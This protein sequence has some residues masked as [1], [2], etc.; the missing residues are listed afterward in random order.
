[1]AESKDPVLGRTIAGKFLVEAYLG[2]GAM[3]AVYRAKQL[4]LEKDVAIKIM[5]GDH[6]GDATYVARFQREA[7]AASRLD[8]PNSMRVIDFGQED[9]GLLYIAMEFLD[10]RDLFRVLQQEWPLPPARIADILSQALAALAVAHEMGIV[11]RDL[12]P[13]NIMLLR[14]T[15]DEGRARD[16]VKVCDFGIAKFTDR[17]D[18]TPQTGGQKLTT[19]GIVVGTPEYMSPEQGKGEALDARSDLYAMGVILY[20]LLTGR[21]PFDAETALG[22]VLKHVTE[23]PVPPSSVHPPSDRQLEAI[24]LKAMRKK[25]EDRYQSAR[26]MR[27]ELRLLGGST[28]PLAHAATQRLAAAHAPTAPAF[29]SSQVVSATPAI[30]ASKLTPPGMS[31]APGEGGSRSRARLFAG[32]ALVAIA[33]GS[34]GF[35][36]RDKIGPKQAAILPVS[37]GP[38]PPPPT[39]T[40]KPLMTDPVPLPEQTPL[41]SAAPSVSTKVGPGPKP[42]PPPRAAAAAVE[43]PAPAAP[44]LPPAPTPEAPAASAN[45]SPPPPT[46]APAPPAPAAP[47]AAAFDPSHAHV[48]WSVTGA[49]G[50][51]TTSGVQRALSRKAGAWT[52]CYR[53]A[54]ERRAERLE[55]TAVLHVVTDETG[56]VVGAHVNGFDQMP[57]VKNCIANAARVKIDGVDTGDAWADVQLT[58]VPE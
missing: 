13:E 38:V 26:E 58:F 20:Q 28:D 50:G 43:P 2:G 23:E 9:D 21:V 46:T 36:L 17:K 56:N 6:A 44:P 35:L 14:G 27:T 8:H 57:G 40:L 45:P 15:D 34:G 25:R 11:H 30:T 29:D 54:L 53:N 24:C 18:G 5:H 32:V 3:G 7:K 42:A 51:A 41:A 10:G 33:L 31:A 52:Q 49:G 12:K 39:A 1:M 19:Q 16:I 48:Q 22:V 4:A 55:G 37:H 47:A